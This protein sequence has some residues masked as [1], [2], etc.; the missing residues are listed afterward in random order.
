[1]IFGEALR[2]VSQRAVLAAKRKIK[3]SGSWERGKLEWR[4]E[5]KRWIDIFR[6]RQFRPKS[7]PER[8]N[9]RHCK[10]GHAQRD[11][12]FHLLTTNCHGST[13]ITKHLA[14]LR[15]HWCLFV[16]NENSGHWRRWFHRV[17]PCREA[18]RGWAR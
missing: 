16:V 1:M 11:Q 9:K 12:S 17:A 13:R 10:R 2:I 3:A 18:P 7:K 4:R 8:G 15:V 5:S 6:P 14:F